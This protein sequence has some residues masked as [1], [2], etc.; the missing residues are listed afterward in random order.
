MVLLGLI[1]IAAGAL[2]VVAAFL[3]AEGTVQLLGT[4]LTAFGLFLVGL[5][6]GLALWWGFELSKFGTRRS[7]RHRRE[8]KRLQQLDQAE[9]QRR[10]DPEDP[11]SHPTT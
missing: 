7:L 10:T 8:S 5:G 6:A 1:L 2:A 11:R 9:N 3:T 4:D